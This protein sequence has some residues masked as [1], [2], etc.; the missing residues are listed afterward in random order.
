MTNKCLLFTS[1][2]CVKCPK[3]KELMEKSYK[4]TVEYVDCGS[5]DGLKIAQEKGIMAV[6]V[7]IFQDE[8]GNDVK[9]LDDYYDIED[10]LDTL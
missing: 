8:E 1:P 9:R 7:V 2:T 10:Y 5:P 3:V 6:P 4:G